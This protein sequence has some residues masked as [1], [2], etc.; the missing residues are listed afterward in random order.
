MNECLFRH[1]NNVKRSI[2]YKNIKITNYT[3]II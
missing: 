1:K 2:V 3:K